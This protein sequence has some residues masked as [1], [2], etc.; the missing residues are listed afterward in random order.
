MKKTTID[1]SQPTFRQEKKDLLHSVAEAL[2][3]WFHTHGRDLPWRH[4]KDPYALWLSEIVMQQTRISQGTDYWQRLMHRWPT[5]QALAA[6]T[7][8]EVLRLWQGLGYYSRARHLHQAA[9]QMAAKGQ[10]PRTA[11]EWCKLP[12]VGAY[13]AAAVASMAFGEAVAA[14]DGNAL[15]VMSRLFLL[16][17]PVDTS[18][19]HQQ[20][21]LWAQALVEQAHAPG[22]FNQAVMD[23]GATLC[24]PT[25]P[26]CHRCP[27]QPQCAAHAAGCAEELPKKQ[28]KV[29]QRSRNLHFVYIRS[30][31]YTALMRRGKG[32][33][34]EGLWQPFLV[35]DAPLP[36]WS[37]TWHEVVTGVR[38]Q[39]THQ[40]LTASLHLLETPTRPPLPS[41]YQWMPEEEVTLHALPRLVERLLQSIKT[42]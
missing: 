37:G 23:L 13:T 42:D 16:T 4:T 9:Q 35:E 2:E 29:K 20:V 39:L 38:H 40:S 17:E 28:K 26:L 27:V 11:A 7:E 36:S 25:Q 1:L 32:D 8:D 10:L 14:V 34:W 30:K 19:G 18:K 33:I 6:A 5:V 31:G 22:A 12:G 21:S 24:T 15:R 41:S 3:Q